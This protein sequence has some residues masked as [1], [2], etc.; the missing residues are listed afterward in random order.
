MHYIIRYILAHFMLC[1]MLRVLKY[2][3]TSSTWSYAGAKTTPW[4]WEGQTP[5]APPPRQQPRRCMP[6]VR[7]MSS[8]SLPGVTPGGQGPDGITSLATAEGGGQPCSGTAARGQGRA[9]RV[10]TNRA[11]A[12]A[13]HEP[14]RKHRRRHTQRGEDFC[15]LNPYKTDKAVM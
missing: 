6:G 1:I 12:Y 8:W 14:A 15:T 5:G 7:P 4:P 2:R 10:V 11:Y 9:S 3:T 13:S